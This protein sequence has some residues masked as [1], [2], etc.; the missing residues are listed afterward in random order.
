VSWLLPVVA[1]V[2]LCVSPGTALGVEDSAPAKTFHSFI[3]GLAAGDVVAVRALVH[4]NALQRCAALRRPD[5][6]PTTKGADRLFLAA[7]QRYERLHQRRPSCEGLFRE[8]VQ[9]VPHSGVDPTW[10]S[11]GSVDLD[12]AGRVAQGS[13]IV[14]GA[15]SG[16]KL[17]FQREGPSWRL[18]PW[19]TL[20]MVGG[21][22]DVATS[23]TG[24]D[25]ASAL[26]LVEQ[27]LQE[28]MLRNVSP[29]LE[30]R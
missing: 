21:L 25:Y 2:L 19:P 12:E 20:T 30:N 26:R 27:G 17:F 14:A 18:D 5:S 28:R 3:A 6:G 1:T 13:L 29:D 4:P 11:L 8:L 23:L 24:L 9:S 16:L 22:V 15:P 7:L 10:F